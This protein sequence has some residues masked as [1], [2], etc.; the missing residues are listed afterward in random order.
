MNIQIMHNLYIETI[1]Q[2]NNDLVS[3]NIICYSKYRKPIHV[4]HR[5]FLKIL[6][7]I[8][9][10]PPRLPVYHDHK[11]CDSVST[12]ILNVEP[13]YI[14]MNLHSMNSLG[15]WRNPVQTI[16]FNSVILTS[17]VCSWRDR[18][19]Q[20]AAKWLVCY[21]SPPEGNTETITEYYTLGSVGQK[22]FVCIV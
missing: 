14:H 1:P 10:K 20:K 8:I 5:D 6:I 9:F 12:N 3:V 7:L 22:P 15:H 11:I 18:D 4:Y 19:R 21:F 13:Y 16:Q 2:V 17:D